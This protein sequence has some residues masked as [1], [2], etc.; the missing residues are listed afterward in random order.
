VTSTQDGWVPPEQPPG[1]ASAPGPFV[2]AVPLGGS[3][4][5][6]EPAAPRASRRELVIAGI[7]LVAAVATGAASL[8]PWRDYGAVVGPRITETGWTLPDGSLGRG[9]IAVLLGVLLAVA[10]IL[11]AADRERAGRVLAVLT[12]STMMVVAIAEWGLGAGRSR[13]GPGPGLWLLFLVGL[14]VV[15]AVGTL[16]PGD[17]RPPA[18]A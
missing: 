10:G 3:G 5:A 14:A 17:R 13:T 18:D 8:M 6:P 1:A 12:G 7:L 11:L 2:A 16:S 9:W 15:V 4:P